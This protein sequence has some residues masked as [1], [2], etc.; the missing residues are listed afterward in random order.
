MTGCRRPLG[1]LCTRSSRRPPAGS[2]IIVGCGVG[3]LLGIV[4]FTISV[5][6][7]PMLLD[8]DVGVAAAVET[9]VRVVLENPQTM[10]LWGLIVAAALIDR[11]FAVSHRS[12]RR[13]P[14]AWTFDVAFVSR[15]C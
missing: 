8:R 2:L 1:S 3:L 10:A 9:S 14:D 12:R 4:A 7:V 5:V 13:L 15:G 11:L 6:S